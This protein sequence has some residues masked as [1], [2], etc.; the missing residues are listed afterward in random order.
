MPIHYF[1]DYTITKQLQQEKLNNP[2]MAE[3]IPV[4]HQN[5]TFEIF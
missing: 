1:G 5:E 2:Y 3:I 4:H